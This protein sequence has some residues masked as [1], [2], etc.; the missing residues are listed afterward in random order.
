MPSP[1]LLLLLSIHLST[2]HSH[3]PPIV[4]INWITQKSSLIPSSFINLSLSFPSDHLSP[5]PNI[6]TW[7]QS[8]IIFPGLPAFI[9]TTLQYILISQLK[10]S[11]RDRNQ[12]SSPI[13][14]PP[15]TS[16]HTGKINNIYYSLKG[17]SLF[18]LCPPLET[19]LL[20][21]TFPYISF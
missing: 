2:L 9:P 19:N 7:D 6:N 3:S 20:F 11:F 1:N 18:G 8:T 5:S 13:K 15:M 21:A 12:M 4:Q 16:H 14:S 17:Y 10:W